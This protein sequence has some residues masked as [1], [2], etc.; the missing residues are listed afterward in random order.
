[1]VTLAIKMADTFHQ[2]GGLFGIF[3]SRWRLLCRFFT[4]FTKM[5]T[6]N[7]KMADIF[8]QDGGLFGI[9]VKMATFLSKFSCLSSGW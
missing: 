4:R 7:I 6:F 9:F 8:H 3:W 5:L 2:D 1:M